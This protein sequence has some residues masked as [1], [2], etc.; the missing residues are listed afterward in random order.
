MKQRIGTVPQRINDLTGDPRL[1]P[2]LLLGALMSFGFIYLR[3][4][5]SIKPKEESD[6][7]SDPKPE[8]AERSKLRRRRPKSRTNDNVPPS[9]TDMEPPNAFQ[10]PFTDSD[11]E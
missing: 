11:S 6:D 8:G 1:G 5:Q 2:M 3:R 10:M 9:I 4:N 7:A